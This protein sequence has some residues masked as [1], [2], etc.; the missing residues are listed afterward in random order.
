[1]KSCI[2]VSSASRLSSSQTNTRAALL[3]LSEL[4]LSAVRR[5]H[6]VHHALQRKDSLEHQDTKHLLLK[7]PHTL[8]YRQS[9][10]C[11]IQM[12]RPEF[13]PRISVTHVFYSTQI[14]P[15]HSL[16]PS[17][18]AICYRC[19]LFFSESQS[20]RH[21]GSCVGTPAQR[22]YKVG[23]RDQRLFFSCKPKRPYVAG[24]RN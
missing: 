16:R 24:A 5:P 18:T 22:T 13:S 8:R 2:R 4:A 21:C 1:M 6:C 17:V 23:A 3:P 20:I 12:A 19:D 15:L 14:Y 10:I 11:I 9:N 7:Y